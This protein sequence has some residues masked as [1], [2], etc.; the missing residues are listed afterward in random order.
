M[1]WLL[2]AV[3]D[4]E[5]QKSSGNK[6]AECGGNETAIDLEAVR[7]GEERLRRL[8]IAH[9]SIEGLAIAIRHVRRI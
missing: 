7:A 5:S 2:L 8:L 3:A 4:L 9:F 1:D 6:R